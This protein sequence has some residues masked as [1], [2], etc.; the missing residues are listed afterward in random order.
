VSAFQKE[1]AGASAENAF[2]IWNKKGPLGKLHNLVVYINW[3]DSRREDF[4][5][6]IRE[7][8]V[9]DIGEDEL[10]VIKLVSDGGV[11]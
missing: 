9:Q 4:R 1:L 6:A 10:P 2:K 8:N 11:R 3:N 7:A 5:R